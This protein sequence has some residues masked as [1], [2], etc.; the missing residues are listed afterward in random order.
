[1]SEPQ[2]TVTHHH[3]YQFDV[4]LVHSL[5]LE[6]VT[7]CDAECGQSVDRPEQDPEA[8]VMT[9]K[10]KQYEPM[11][12]NLLGGKYQL[13]QNGFALHSTEPTQIF[14]LT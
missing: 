14:I 10:V 11:V 12:I 2:G 8:A 5:Q 3:L 7:S 9:V 13:K 4:S 1:M 6:F